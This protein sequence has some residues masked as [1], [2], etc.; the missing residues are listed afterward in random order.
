MRPLSQTSAHVH[1]HA[2]VKYAYVNKGF[3]AA[4]VQTPA[5]SQTG[6]PWQEGRSKFFYRV[7]FC[8]F[9]TNHLAFAM[10]GRKLLIHSSV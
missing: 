3:T 1:M 5:H 10:A 8:V 9:Y 4:S 2:Y 6:Y 7:T